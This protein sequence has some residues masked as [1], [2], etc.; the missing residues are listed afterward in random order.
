MITRDIRMA[1]LGLSGCNSAAGGKIIFNE[2]INGNGLLDAG[3]DANGNG[4]APQVYDGLGYDGSDIITAV[5]YPFNP[6]GTA[7]GIQTYR[8]LQGRLATLLYSMCMT[9]Q[10]LQQVI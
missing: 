3:E 5:Y 1:G 7:G 8:D 4:G 9:I 10:V 6:Q 2:D